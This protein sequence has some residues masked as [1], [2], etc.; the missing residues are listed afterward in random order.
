MER[1]ESGLGDKVERV[2]GG[3][4]EMPPN[5]SQGIDRKTLFVSILVTLI[6]TLGIMVFY[7]MPQLVSKTDFTQNT[8]SIAKDIADIKST[9]ATFGDLSAQIAALSGRI[10]AVNSG[11]S[12]LK[13]TVANLDSGQGSVKAL[14]SSLTTIQAD[15]KS[16]KTKV[17]A[18]PS[19]KPQV[20]ALQK[21]LDS[22]KASVTAITA[23]VVKLETPTTTTSSSSTSKKLASD[24][25]NGVTVIIEPHSHYFIP[26]NPQ[27][28]TSIQTIAVDTDDNGDGDVTFQL[29]VE[30]DTGQTIKDLVVTLI[31]GLFDSD[32]KSKTLNLVQNVNLTSFGYPL[33]NVLTGSKNYLCFSG[34]SYVYMS[35]SQEVGDRGY[36]CTL[37]IPA[38]AGAIANT[39]YLLYPQIKVVSFNKQ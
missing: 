11:L 26:Y 9:V 33:S 13:G 35:F 24:T 3:Y 18:I 25:L 8:Q 23:R 21:S 15:L 20:D 27:I 12:G 32:Y 7:L 22:L 6:V 38:S 34:G 16:L 1:K 37:T 19:L 4:E 17:D 10:E 39:T 36:F 30:N 14:Q 5:G 2:A 29:V 31:F 28:G